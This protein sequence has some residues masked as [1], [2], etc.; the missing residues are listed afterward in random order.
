MRKKSDGLKRSHIH[1]KVPANVVITTTQMTSEPQIALVIVGPNSWICAMVSSSCIVVICWTDVASVFFPSFYFH[2]H[3]PAF[4]SVPSVW[5]RSF[6]TRTTMEMD[7]CYCTLAMK[8]PFRQMLD[9]VWR[10]QILNTQLRSIHFTCDRAVQSRYI[11]G[12]WE[13]ICQ[14]LFCLRHK[15]GR[16]GWRYAR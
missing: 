13:G 8:K 4:A 12:C 7:S 9:G 16:L 6:S 1:F 14:S 5:R 15:F 3:A 11:Q 10:P 2:F